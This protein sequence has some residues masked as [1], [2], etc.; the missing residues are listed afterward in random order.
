MRS[1]ILILS[2]LQTK[3]AVV[4]VYVALVIIHSGILIVQFY[5]GLFLYFFCWFFI[6]RRVLCVI[7]GTGTASQPAHMRIRCYFIVNLHIT[8]TRSILFLI[9]YVKKLTILQH[10]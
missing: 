1:W 4:L 10:E 8:K 3:G 7:K 9:K 6:F 5:L 2:M